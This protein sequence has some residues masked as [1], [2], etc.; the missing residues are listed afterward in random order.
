[1]ESNEIQI[2]NEKSLNF[3]HVALRKE[4]LDLL[5]KTE[6]KYLEVAVAVGFTKPFPYHLFQKLVF[7][8]DMNCNEY[9]PKIMVLL[10]DRFSREEL[11]KFY[12]EVIC[13]SL[14][15]FDKNDIVKIFKKENCEPVSLDFALGIK[16]F[17]DPELQDY[18]LDRVEQQALGY[19]ELEVLFDHYGY[20]TRGL[21]FDGISE[22]YLRGVFNV[23]IDKVMG[24]V[25]EQY[26]EFEILSFKYY[27]QRSN[28]DYE[29]YSDSGFLIALDYL[30]G[31]LCESDNTKNHKLRL[32]FEYLKTDDS[33]AIFQEKT[34]YRNFFKKI[35]K[36]D[37]KLS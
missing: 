14:G 4:M 15:L 23:N 1:M 31:A 21:Y 32:Y 20:K 5:P 3:Q 29:C 24:C 37:G 10:K 33:S 18:W 11:K 2:D 34:H 19:S 6:E 7:L 9:I 35:I 22:F 27:L 26:Y 12:T 8:W 28:P 25:R 13:S 16:E 17:D 30:C 36:R